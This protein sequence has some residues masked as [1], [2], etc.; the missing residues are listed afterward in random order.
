[1]DATE[2][3]VEFD[4]MV[5]QAW[6]TDG[7]AA[8]RQKVEARLVEERQRRLAQYRRD[9]R[10]AYAW[11]YLRRK[12]LLTPVGNLGP[13]RIPRLRVAGREEHQVE[14][15]HPGQGLDDGGRGRGTDEPGGFG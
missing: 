9:G 4:G 8:T 15:H 7:I 10:K 13:V 1:M 3:I 6:K 11:G 14:R 12:T 5:M 2:G